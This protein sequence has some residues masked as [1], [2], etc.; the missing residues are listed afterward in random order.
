MLGS[1]LR[2]A[3]DDCTARLCRLRLL[4][5]SSAS[6]DKPRTNGRTSGR[7]T[8]D[9]RLGRA[10]RRPDHASD[11]AWRGRDAPMSADT[12]QPAWRRRG[13]SPACSRRVW[14]GGR[15]YFFTRV[16]AWRP[17]SCDPHAAVARIGLYHTRWC[18][19]W[20]AAR[21]GGWAAGSCPDPPPAR[22][23]R[24]AP[25]GGAHARLLPTRS[26]R[27][28]APG[29]RRARA[30]GPSPHTQTHTH[31]TTAAHDEQG[32]REGE[33][34]SGC[35]VASAATKKSQGGDVRDPHTHAC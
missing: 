7:M 6:R 15:R 8:S 14:Q 26:A 19:R 35:W 27:R 23:H 1:D 17:M 31:H 33:S 30:A 11:G 13:Q 2:R 20:C 18:C 12:R 32:G 28:P 22:H 21:L 25:R 24:Q 34:E 3:Q 10:A 9:G 5:H 16:P 29:T 4:D